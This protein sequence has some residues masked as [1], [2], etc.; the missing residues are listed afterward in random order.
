MILRW[1]KNYGV[2]K[3]KKIGYIGLNK[4][5][6]IVIPCNHAYVSLS[7]LYIPLLSIVSVTKLIKSRFFSYIFDI[8]AVCC[9]FFY[10]KNLYQVYFKPFFNFFHVGY[11]F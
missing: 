6:P 3:I 8:S 2:A 5:Y 11:G 7:V 9:H 10:L 4:N 1:I